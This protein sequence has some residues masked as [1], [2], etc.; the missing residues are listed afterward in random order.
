MIS[1]LCITQPG[2]EEF[3]KQAIACFNEQTFPDKELVIVEDPK[4][5]ITLGELRNLAVAKSTGDMLAVWDDDDLSDPGRLECQFE[6]TKDISL[7]EHVTLECAC[8]VQVRSPARMW[9]CSMMIRRE[10]MPFYASLPRG[11]DTELLQRLRDS[12]ALI[13]LIDGT[14]LYTKRFHGANTWEAVHNR[15]LF[16]RCRPHHVCERLQ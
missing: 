5:G 8:G 12:R 14:H 7:F 4:T 6:A 3:L 16:E 13:T 11:E 1:C 9:E 15:A 10:I 2:R